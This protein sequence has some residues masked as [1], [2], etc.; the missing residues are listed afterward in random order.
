MPVE[1]AAS[2]RQLRRRRVKRHFDVGERRRRLLVRHRLAAPGR[3][4]EEVAGD[5]VGLHATDPATVYLSLQQRLPGFTVDDLDAALYER[6]SVTRLL[7]MR[8]TMF[9]V[10]LDLAAVVDAACTKALIAP[11]RRRTTQLL[12]AEGIE[13]GEALVRDACAAT[14]ALLR[15]G[16]PLP[17]RALTPIVTQLQQQVLLAEG[18]PYEARVSITNRILL[19]LSIEGLIVRTRPLGSW[20]SSQYRWTPTDQWFAEP[21]P[22][23]PAAA[24]RTELVR[25]WLRTY[26]PGTTTD[27]A[28]WA[29]WTK[30][31][32]VDALGELDAV[33][34][35][36]EP[37]PGAAPAPAWV[38]ADDLDDDSTTTQPPTRPSC[39]CCRRSTR[40]SWDGRSVT[41]SSATTARSSSTA[42]A[43]P[44]RS[45]LVDGAVVGGWAQV[46]DGRVV[47]ELI[48]PVSAAARRRITAAAAALTEW[49]DGV[50]V[51]PRFPDAAADAPRHRHRVTVAAGTTALVRSPPDG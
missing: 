20:L 27:I 12:E 48:R 31:Q 11:E 18:K 49:F 32:V 33:A 38:L 35:T 28:W 43:M 25:R 41:G 2:H 50:R 10:P 21:W 26:G 14:L 7:G 1:L 15:K 44:A 37:A 9:V 42:T 8:R 16:E 3:S 46:D 34:V 30:R 40:R 47:T 17:A 4:V 51:T 45:I 5:L 22:E 23:I 6:R 29:K 13:S 19:Q 36:V 39:R 24:A